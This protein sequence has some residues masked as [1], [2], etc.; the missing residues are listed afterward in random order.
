[1]RRRLPSVDWKS[2]VTPKKTCAL[3]APRPWPCVSRYSSFVMSAQQRFGWFFTKLASLKTLHSCGREV[4]RAG[5]GEAGQRRGAKW[6]ISGPVVL[7]PVAWRARA[8]R[9]HER[10]PA[11]ACAR[12]RARGVA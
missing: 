4:G 9:V 2:F 8:Q 12:A 6:G 10:A 11:R 1:M 3:S 7:R 5:R